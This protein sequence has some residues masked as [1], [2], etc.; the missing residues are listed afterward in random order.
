MA[1]LMMFA[2][3]LVMTIAAFWPNGGKEESLQYVWDRGNAPAGFLMSYHAA[4]TRACNATGTPCGA[5]MI[6]ASQIAPYMP[7][8]VAT[9]GAMFNDGRFGSFSDG[10]YIYSYF[11]GL[12]YNTQ[13]KQM[14]VT[15][16]DALFEL[17]P[18]DALAS[19]GTYDASTGVFTPRNSSYVTA[20]TK[21]TINGPGQPRYINAAAYG[22]NVRDYSAVLATR[23]RPGN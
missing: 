15:A 14:R 2:F 20:G 10:T 5:G 4:A 21:S 18:S 8:Y 16:V 12:G 22:A 9:N 19:A 6:P 3:V 17:L 23:L 7:S 13:G 1:V 11:N